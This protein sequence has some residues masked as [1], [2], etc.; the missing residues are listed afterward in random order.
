MLFFNVLNERLFREV[1]FRIYRLY[2]YR[3]LDLEKMLENN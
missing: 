1:G 3:M 2:N